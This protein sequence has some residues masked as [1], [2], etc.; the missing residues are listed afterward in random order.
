MSEFRRQALDDSDQ[1]PELSPELAFL[2][3]RQ[4]PMAVL[5]ERDRQA[6]PQL[7]ERYRSE[8]PS[9]ELT[10]A[11]LEAAGDIATVLQSLRSRQDLLEVLESQDKVPAPPL[12]VLDQIQYSYLLLTDAASEEQ[13]EALLK[14]ED[15][16]EM[17]RIERVA[18]WLASV[19]GSGESP[20]RS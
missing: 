10:E 15:L 6:Y 18:D 16:D 5:L 9:P 13:R 1:P 3:S 7:L 20:K 19:L 17:L 11:A 12:A 2:A 8:G 4:A 14:P